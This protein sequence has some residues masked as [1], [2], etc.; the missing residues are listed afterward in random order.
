MYSSEFGSTLQGPMAITAYL[1]IPRVVGKRQG[2]RHRS[3]TKVA[4][5]IVLNLGHS[6][7]HTLQYGI[8]HFMAPVIHLTSQRI[9]YPHLCLPQ[10][11][12]DLFLVARKSVIESLTKRVHKRP[13]RAGSERFAGVRAHAV[14]TATLLS[15]IYNVVSKSISGK[16][17]MSPGSTHSHQ[18][19]QVFQ[20]RCTEVAQVRRWPGGRGR[21]QPVCLLR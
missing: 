4:H 5:D 7:L 1:S 14:H 10:H 2:C 16:Q 19:V 8:V 3:L 9:Q 6:V 12:C 15:P 21:D 11:L 17:S 18:G 20:S 13:Y